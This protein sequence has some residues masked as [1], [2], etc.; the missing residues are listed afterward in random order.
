MKPEHVL[1]SPSSLF[2]QVTDFPRNFLDLPQADEKPSPLELAASFRKQ[3]VNYPAYAHAIRAV[4]R[5]HK[6]GKAGLDEPD[7]LLITGVSGAG[8]STI[9][10]QYAARFPRYED[11]DRTRIPVLHLQLPSQPTIKNVAE[12]MLLEMGDPF[13]DRSTAESKTARIITLLRECRTELIILDEFQHFVDSARGKVDYV[14]ADWLKQIINATRIPFV[15]M[16]LPRCEQILVVNEQLRRRFNRKIIIRP[17][18]IKTKREAEQFIGLLKTLESTVPLPK[19]SCL[20]S[21]NLIKPIY[22]ATAGLIDFLIK[23]VG[24]AT[25]LAAEDGAQCLDIDYLS[26]AFETVILPGCSDEMN[27]F[28]EDFVQRIL[29]REGEPFHGYR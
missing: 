26:K 22:Y 29:N 17:F 2:P 10:K 18:G 19:P 1:S 11:P 25:E 9:R 4:E 15:L 6:M 16:G 14:V 28:C 3:I 24:T 27:P 20:S 23:L 21:S 12:R 7:C 5:C 8:K 13:A